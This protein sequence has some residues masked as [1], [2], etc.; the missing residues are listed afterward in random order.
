MIELMSQICVICKEKMESYVWY[1]NAI[2]F[3]LFFF[4]PAFLIL[5]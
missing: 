2:L 3:S 4:T 1:L 5:H